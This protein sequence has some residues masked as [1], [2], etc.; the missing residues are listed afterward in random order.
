MS[1]CMRFALGILLF[2]FYVLT[3]AL[4]CDVGKLNSADVKQKPQM[5]ECIRM[6]CTS[7]ISHTYCN[8][9]RVP[10]VPRLLRTPHP[11]ATSPGRGAN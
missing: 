6:L 2:L 9:A 1:Q 11:G 7:I 3:V 4:T 10:A 8:G 5:H